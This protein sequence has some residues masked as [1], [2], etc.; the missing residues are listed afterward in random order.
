ME[1]LLLYSNDWEHHKRWM[2]LSERLWNAGFEVAHATDD[3]DI[4][5]VLAI[6]KCLVVTVP[7]Y[8]YDLLISDSKTTPFGEATTLDEFEVMLDD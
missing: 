1:K 8:R 5:P 3:R 6:A 7:S 4:V 2:D